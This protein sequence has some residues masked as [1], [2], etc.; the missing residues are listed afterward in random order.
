VPYSSDREV[1]TQGVAA[2]PETGVLA[3]SDGAE[4]AINAIPYVTQTP[5]GNLLA[6]GT[7]HR[8][9]SQPKLRIVGAMSS[10]SG[11]T[12]SAPLPLIDN[13]AR[14][15]PTQASSLTA[16]LSSWVST[17]L[18]VPGKIL[19]TEFWMTASDDEGKTWSKPVLA[20]HSHTYAEGKMHASRR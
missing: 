14:R 12:W 6:A 5:G 20:S 19:T 2:Q 16:T 3:R 11:R 8:A 1:L 7:V 18:P 15:M 10:D 13:P 4:F 17:T 9:E